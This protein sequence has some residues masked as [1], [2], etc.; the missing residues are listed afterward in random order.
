MNEDTDGD[1]INDGIEIDQLRTDPT[2][3]DSDQNG[4]EDGD[5]DSDEDGLKNKE[6]LE[7]GTDPLN[8]DT[9]GDGLNDFEEINTYGTDP[10]N[11][12]TDEDE[13]SDK[14]EIEI[15]TDPLKKEESFHVTEQAEGDGKVQASVTIDLR[16]EQVET[17]T[18]EPT[19]TEFLFPKEMPGYIGNAYEF[20]VDGTFDSAKLT[21]TFDKEFLKDKDFDPVIYYYNENIGLEE[22]PTSIHGN[23][24]TTETTH[25]S[26]YILL[27]R[28]EYE[29]SFTWIDSCPI[30]VYN[31]AEV[32]F[33]MDDTGSMKT[34][35]KSF[36]RLSAAKDMIEM[37]PDSCKIGIVRFSN[38]SK[39]LTKKLVA[40]KKEAEKYFTTDY[41]SSSGGTEMYKAVKN[42]FSLYESND[43]KTLKIMIV[44]TDSASKN[45]EEHEATIQQ[46]KEKDVRIYTVGL[47]TTTDYFKKYLKPL[48]EDT[49]GIFYVATDA[50][51]IKEVFEKCNQRI[52]LQVDS[53]GDGLSDYLEDNLTLFN[54][55]KI[56]TDKNKSDS[57]EDGLKDGEEVILI[58][59]QYRNVGKE[60]RLVLL[61]KSNPCNSDTDGDGLN[62]GRVS[63]KNGNII[64][65]IDPDPDTPNGPEGLWN[66]HIHQQDVRVSRK[67]KFE[68]GYSKK[69]LQKYINEGMKKGTTK[70]IVHQIVEW[71]LNMKNTVKQNEKDIKSFAKFLKRYTNGNRATK[72]GVAILNFVKDTDD[73]AY[74]SR[75]ETW[76][77]SFGYNEFY[78]EVFRMGTKMN[79]QDFPFKVGNKEYA[80]WMWKGNYWNLH[81]GAEI[82]LYKYDRTHNGTKHYDAI[83]FE[84]PMRLSLYKYSNNGKQID[85]IF[86][87]YPY[88][89]QW[90]ITGFSGDKSQFR[91]T[92]C[93]NMAA[94]GYVDLSKHIDMY[95]GI[96]NAEKNYKR[97]RKI[98]YNRYL[99]FDD[100]NHLIWVFWHE[101]VKNVEKK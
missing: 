87:W 63:F 79:K 1:G 68:H 94:I 52:G 90:W 7:I 16:G 40:D 53:D 23:T 61:G 78:D 71:A 54:G 93:N 6:E 2:M 35:D 11:E 9:D 83:D 75:V 32:V 48:A 55:V 60:M 19:G 36:K 50:T 38:E 21:F 46:A 91:N 31:N 56:K 47:G 44:L 5:E 49:G 80:L 22:M 99:I 13:V 62:D 74:H 98:A 39:K 86:N 10:L 43:T 84:V 101:G 58:N 14:K 88:G 95:N 69:K 34:N 24:A 96:K 67:Y 85:T 100:K 73:E 72:V 41:F 82:G 4:I 45:L 76:Q 25:F 33:V 26:K 57:D 15:G 27:N 3:S 28:K 51:K 59:P 66:A 77:R 42:A 37:L 17:L 97:D 70:K 20:S 8:E 65:P 64:A 12:D 29:N 92:N 89:G 81:S 30:D 18:V